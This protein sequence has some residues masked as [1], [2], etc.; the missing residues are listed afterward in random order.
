METNV[1]ITGHVDAYRIFEI[2]NLSPVGNKI[3]RS[4]NSDGT[5]HECDVYQNFASIDCLGFIVTEGNLRGIVLLQVL[6][7]A[8]I[9]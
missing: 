1:T 6:R 2:L 7:R 5:K 8:G 9:A 3:G 4:S